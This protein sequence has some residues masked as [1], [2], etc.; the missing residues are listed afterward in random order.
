MINHKI[1]NSVSI[2]NHIKYQTPKVIQYHD[3]VVLSER[4]VIPYLSYKV[5]PPL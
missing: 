5:P 2:A 4:N 3:I 1:F